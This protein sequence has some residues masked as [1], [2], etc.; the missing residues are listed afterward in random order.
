[1]KQTFF[2]PELKQVIQT[3]CSSKVMLPATTKNVQQYLNGISPH[4]WIG[5]LT[6]FKNAFSIKYFLPQY[7]SRVSSKDNTFQY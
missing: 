1:M 3:P 2:I 5:R 7:F 6:E 4:K